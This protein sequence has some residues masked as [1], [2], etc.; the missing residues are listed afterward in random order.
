MNIKETSST[1]T[2]QKTISIL[3]T[4][5]F[6]IFSRIS[7]FLI[8]S[9][10][11]HASIGLS[12]DKNTFFSFN[13]KRGFCIEKPIKKKRKNPCILY[14]IQ[15]PAQSYDE[16]V[17]RIGDFKNNANQYKYSFIGAILCVLHIPFKCENKYFCSQF[18]SELL[19]LS[20][21]AKLRTKP[22]LYLPKYF[23]KEPQFTLSYKGMLCG[24]CEA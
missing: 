1:N 13:T 16:I 8:G 20:G 11:T 22:T 3:L 14:Q 24:L 12:D 18:V 23:S 7:Q 17:T 4:K 6:D 21:A 5:Q 2:E 9:E 15:V 19:T 10:Y